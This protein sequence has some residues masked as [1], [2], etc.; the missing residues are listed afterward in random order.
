MKK[1]QMETSVG[2]FVLVCLLCV[3]YLTVKLGKLE[4][5]GADDYRLQAAFTSVAG[6][7]PGAA[8]QIAGVQVGSVEG[9][10]LRMDDGVAMVTLSVKKGIELTDDT[11]AS[12]KTSG[13]I[14]DK[15]LK[16]TP[17]GSPDILAPGDTI[18]ET[19]APLDIEELIGKYVF[20]DVEE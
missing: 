7:K 4:L 13:L 8:V 11:I 17:G 14:G 16:L 19:E 1:Y 3:G 12:I 5:F 10:E 20:G 18:Y 9:I 6:L 15:Y 2:V